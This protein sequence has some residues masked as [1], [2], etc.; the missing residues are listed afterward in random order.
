MGIGNVA[1][2]FIISAGSSIHQA[3][4]V[5]IG[6]TNHE[7][8]RLRVLVCIGILS[9]TFVERHPHTDARMLFKGIDD[10]VT[11][12]VEDLVQFL[13][14]TQLTTVATARHILPNDEAIAVTPFVPQVVL[15]FN[16][17]TYHIHSQRLDGLQVIDHCFVGR[18]S[19]KT[20]GPPSLI[21]RSIHEYGFSI[22]QE[23]R[24]PIY[25]A[26]CECAQAEVT[27][28]SVAFLTIVATEIDVE[29]VEER[30][31]GRPQLGIGNGE[32]HLLTDL[33][34]CLSG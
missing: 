20:V 33:D 17:F 27:S 28:G 10:V 24:M 6:T 12:F 8:A 29:I 22:Q 1:N 31:I 34:F 21:E 3:T 18:G 9:P 13:L 7:I 19:Q 26:L 14:S 5:G 4:H 11:L 32:R 30:R 15:H 23:S 16:V 2:P 25:H